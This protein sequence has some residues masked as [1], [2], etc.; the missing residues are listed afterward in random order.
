MLNLIRSILFINILFVLSVDVSDAAEAPVATTSK[1]QLAT[2]VRVDGRFSAAVQRALEAGDRRQALQLCGASCGGTDAARRL[3]A[4][5]GPGG[6]PDYQS[7]N[8]NSAC[9]SIPDCVA[10]A[11]VCA[12]GTTG[13]ND[14]G[15]TCQEQAEED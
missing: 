10:M 3:V 9:T 8:G 4:R 12:A 13:C 6:T 7:Q 14:Y 5:P 1:L 2:P 15:C 11:D